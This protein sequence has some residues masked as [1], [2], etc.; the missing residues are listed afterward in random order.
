MKAKL[1]FIL[2]IL[3][4]L[5][6]YPLH[7]TSV[8]WLVK[9]EYD[10][11]SYYDKEILKCKKDG[12]CQL[13]DLTGKKLLPM[14]AD[15]I[16]EFCN[17]YALVLDFMDEKD[18][19]KKT[20][21]FLSMRIK[22]LL[23]EKGH[24]FVE[25]DG[26]FRTMFYSYFSEGMLA[27]SN[28]KGEFGYLDTEGRLR[29]KC[30]YQNA[31]PFIKGWASVVPNNKKKT[32]IF[33]DKY[34]NPLIVYYNNGILIW[35]SNF[36]D[37]GE[38]LVMSDEGETVVINTK[39]NKLRSVEYTD[40]NSH[41]R[42]YYD[43]AYQEDDEEYNPPHN[44]MPDFR[45]DIFPI[46]SA[47]GLLGYMIEKD[48][49]LLPQLSQADLFANDYAIV[50]LNDKFGVVALVDGAFSSSIDNT[51]IDPKGDMTSQIKYTLQ[52]PE[53][54]DV[55]QLV[56]AF[57]KGEGELQ[58]M[59][60]GM[61][62]FGRTSLN[63]Y[64]YAFKPQM[65]K[66]S[67]STVIRAEIR[68][69]NLLLWQDKKEITI[70]EEK[71]ALPSTPN[72]EVIK[73]HTGSQK[74]ANFDNILTVYSKVINHTDQPVDVAIRFEIPPLDGGNQVV[75]TKTDFNA[76]VD[77]DGQKPFSI[78]FEVRKRQTIK[79]TVTA[80]VTKEDGDSETFEKSQ[81]I[82]LRPSDDFSD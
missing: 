10:A 81:T 56:I 59:T 19:N 76:K 49:L 75:S 41:V 53:D 25:I 68:L 35:A 2:F 8:K 15:S 82:I 52:V 14:A 54:L 29:I 18:R 22:G 13:I 65:A 37:N 42:T 46:S 72:F 44:D 23:T 31:R 71:P 66:S 70:A 12:K 40:I 28:A 74:R 1:I 62:E 21:D 20:S 50:A 36:N 57:D 33:I 43:Y 80:I 60:L 61:G 69:D 3:A 24:R 32:T 6:T 45:K 39:G 7:A 11:I 38:A 26:D 5:S 48:T 27:V 64:T 79:V 78:K 77:S 67:Q 4:F 34:E 55:G 47:N 30:H 17:G 16:T 73:P 9:P 51:T 58:Q 63:E